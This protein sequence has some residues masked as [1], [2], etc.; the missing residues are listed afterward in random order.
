[1]QDSAAASFSPCLVNNSPTNT[2]SGFSNP[3]LH[4]N[5]DA[6]YLDWRNYTT[7]STRCRIKRD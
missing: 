4:L 2:S 6:I 5:P 1:V 3:Q 7:P